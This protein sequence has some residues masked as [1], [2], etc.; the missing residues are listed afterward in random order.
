MGNPTEL[1]D[2]ISHEDAHRILRHLA[3]SDEKLAAEIDALIHARL[4][5]VDIDEIAASLCGDLEFLTPEDVWERSGAKRYGYVEPGEAA[6]ALIQEILQ[7]YLDEM[8]QAKAAGLSMAVEQMCLGLLLGFYQFEF[9]VKGDFKEWA[10]DAPREFAL[11]V[12]LAWRAKLA[13]DYDVSTALA[14]VEQELPKWASVLEPYLRGE[15][16]Y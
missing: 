8:Q 7:P 5:D 11:S 15:R 10:P 9:E 14:F 3:A 12:A 16:L 1:I 13:D 6:D 2:Q 4:S